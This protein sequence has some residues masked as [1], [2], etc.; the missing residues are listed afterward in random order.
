MVFLWFSYGFPMV[1]LWNPLQLCFPD[2]A[3]LHTEETQ[4]LRRDA[5]GVCEVQATFDPGAVWPCLNHSLVPIY[6]YIYI[7]IIYSTYVDIGDHWSDLIRDVYP[8]RN[9]HF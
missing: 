4:A 7:Y 1:S 2:S 8:S 3:E 9:L 6:I 5:G